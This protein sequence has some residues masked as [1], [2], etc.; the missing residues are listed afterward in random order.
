MPVFDPAVFDEAVFDAASGGGGGG[1]PVNPTTIMGAG[2]VES[3]IDAAASDLFQNTAG[4]TPATADGDPVNF[5]TGLEGPDF[6]AGASSGRNAV[7]RDPGGDPYLEAVAGSSQLRA[8]LAR[9]GD[10]YVITRGRWNGTSNDQESFWV[11]HENPT[12]F[13][14]GDFIKPTYFPYGF[15]Y[16][17][18]E[19]NIGYAVTTSAVAIT[20]GAWSTLEIWVSGSTIYTA[21][22]GGTPETYAASGPLGDTTLMDLFGSLDGGVTGSF[23]VDIRRLAVLNAIPDS[24]ERAALLD[25]AENGDTGGGAAPDPVTATGAVS[26]AIAATGAADVAVSAA[27][28][29]TL[30]TSV[31]GV[32]MAGVAAAG[33]V[34]LG[35]SGAGSAEAFVAAVGDATLALSGAGSAAIAVTGAGSVTL[36]MSC[37]G[38][39]AVALTASGGGEITFDLS[40]SGTVGE[41]APAIEASGAVEL[42]IAASGAASVDVLASGAVGLSIGATG[43]ARISVNAAG[44]GAMQAAVSGSAMAQVSGAGAVSIGLSVSGE[45]EAVFP[46]IEATGAVVFPIEATGAAEAEVRGSGAVSLAFSG[47]GAG[48]VAVRGAGAVGLSITAAGIGFVGQVSLRRA[49][50][51]E[52]SAAGG[53]LVGS[54]RGGTLLSGT[55]PRAGRLAAVAYGDSE[56]GSSGNSG[57]LIPAR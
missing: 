22:D 44:S 20:R 11:I 29:A 33:S 46:P 4:T 5:I 48:R 18:T 56:R 57:A 35:L 2:E 40:G 8:S 32:A 34:S 41:A 19:S 24:T 14:S 53:D 13:Y 55:G 15:N 28:S 26:L 9:S 3:Y 10:F 31:A 16:I 49:A 37:S 6:V 17:Q 42:T 30:E 43:A 38:A 47:A 25:W 12:Q 45:A 54:E 7:L 50:L 23:A 21:V 27:G 39:G 52:D 1:A 36:P 51:A